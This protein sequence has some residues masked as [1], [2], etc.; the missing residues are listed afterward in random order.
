M[1]E[2]ISPEEWRTRLDLAVNAKRGMWRSLPRAMANSR[3]LFYT[4]FV[5]LIDSS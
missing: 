3:L 5:Q 1:K 2:K 4:A